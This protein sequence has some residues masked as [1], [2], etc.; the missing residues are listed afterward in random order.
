MTT[1]D[2]NG[3]SETRTTTP[4]LFDGVW[5]IVAALQ[6]AYQRRQTV[7]RLSPLDA[8]QLADIGL[9]P[10]D[11]EDARNGDGQMLWL[12]ISRRDHTN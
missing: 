5:H 12:K 6:L 1:Y 4:R 2:L 8:Q 10:T 9:E 11:V 3:M 7:L